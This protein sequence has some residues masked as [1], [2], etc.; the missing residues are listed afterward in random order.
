LSLARPGIFFKQEKAMTFIPTPLLRQI[1]Q[2]ELPDVIGAV[3]RWVRGDEATWRYARCIETWGAEFE[4]YRKGGHFDLPNLERSAALYDLR[5]RYLAQLGFMIPCAELLNELQ[6]ADLVVDVGAGTGF[7][8]R[9]M[10]NR[11]IKVIGSD[12]RLGYAHIVKHGTYDALQI[13]PQGKTMVR[14]HP[15]ALVFCS[16]PSLD[17]TWFR[18]ML[19]AMRV[20]QRIVTVLED[21]CCEESAR[22]YFD[23]CFE[24]ERMI[25]IPAFVHMNDIGYVA[26]K[27]RNR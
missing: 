25:D 2:Q 5:S 18:Q 6:K 26:M 8:T 1:A 7:M 15:D 11:G 4:M 23:A 22:E 27:K 24:V 13:A 16:W 19:K 10:R 14:R 12:P 9:I 21:S 20:G 3:E 17:E